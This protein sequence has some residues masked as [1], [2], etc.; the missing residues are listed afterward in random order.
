MKVWALLPVQPWDEGK[1]RLATVLDAAA[2]E[3]LN[4]KFFQHVL[5]VAC[6]VCDPARTIVVSRSQDVMAEARQAGVRTLAERPGGGLNQA[7]TDAAKTAAGLGAEAVL[8]VSCDLPLLEAAD[9]RAM[10]D[11]APSRGVVIAP[12][13]TGLGTNGLLMHP[14]DAIAYAYGEGSFLRH[15]A[16][17]KAAGLDTVVLRRGG[18]AHD[19]DTP[20]DLMRLR[21]LRAEF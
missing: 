6:D 16:A 5:S 8:S 18:L 7:L 11:A 20:P 17:C 9:L 19:I 1:T 13:H 14:V 2:R 10:L 21:I 15:K 4:R 12:D 3:A